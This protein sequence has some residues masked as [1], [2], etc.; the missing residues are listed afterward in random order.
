MTRTIL[1]TP[2][3]LQKFEERVAAYKAKMEPKELA[4]WRL[5]ALAMKQPNASIKFDGTN[6][7]VEKKAKDL[8]NI[9][10]PTKDLKYVNCP[11]FHVLKSKG[12]IIYGNNDGGFIYEDGSDL[13]KMADLD[14]LLD[15]TTDDTYLFSEHQTD[16]IQSNNIFIHKIAVAKI[17]NNG[18]EGLILSMADYNMPKIKMTFTIDPRIASEFSSII[19]C[20]GASKSSFVEKKMLEFIMEHID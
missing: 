10:L 1:T 4:M 3:Q 16:T 7:D 9:L 15:L 18:G 2:E 6:P 13:D 5:T 17:T 20:T 11:V 8:M 14:D 12:T 19:E